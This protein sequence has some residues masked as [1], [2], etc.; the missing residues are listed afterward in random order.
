MDEATGFGFVQFFEAPVDFVNRS[1][2]G[3]PLL[4]GQS[5]ASDCQLNLCGYEGK[6]SLV[7]S[8]SAGI[9]YFVADEIAVQITHHFSNLP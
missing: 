1:F 5:F 7:I 9:G 3:V 6:K 8:I 2:D 4:I